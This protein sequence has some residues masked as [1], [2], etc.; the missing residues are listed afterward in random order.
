MGISVDTLTALGA[1]M[2]FFSFLWVALVGAPVGP[3]V[4]RLWRARRAGQEEEQPVWSEAFRNKIDAALDEW[5]KT[6]KRREE[7]ERR[8]EEREE[9]REQREERREERERRAEER[10]ERRE[11]RERRAEEREE[12]REERERRAEER[13]ERRE[14]RERRAEE[15]ELRRE[16]GEL[17]VLQ[18]LRDVMVTNTVATAGAWATQQYI[19]QLLRPA[20]PSS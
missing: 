16:E 4:L 12:R 7:R 14:E 10:E 13:E 9:R 17:R 2:T 8:A 1:W 6:R 20:R 5:E 19:A 3:L 15:R 18:E 11:E